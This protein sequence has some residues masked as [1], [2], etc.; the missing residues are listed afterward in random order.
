MVEPPGRTTDISKHPCS[1]ASRLLPLKDE[2]S[3]K[4]SVDA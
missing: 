4:Q 1:A 2:K 3:T